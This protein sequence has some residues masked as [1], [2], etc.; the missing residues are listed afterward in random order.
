MNPRHAGTQ[1]GFT[2]L[3]LS[4]VLV[5]VALVTGMAVSG[6][7]GILSSARQFATNRRMA[8]IEQALVK[9]RTGFD[10]LPCPADLTIAQG[11]AN[12]GVEGA[13]PG[14]CIG[15]TPSANF[16]AAGATYTFATAAEGAVP[17][18]TL[19]LPNDFMYDGWGN[20]FRYAVDISM[21]A[22]GAFPAMSLTCAYG[23]V[24]VKD[25]NGTARSAAA[26]Y[27]L[28]SHGANGHG[29]YTQKGVTLNAGSVNA[30]EQTNCHCNS[31]GAATTYAPVYV[32]ADFSVDS[33]NALDNF[34]DLVTYKE[35]WQMRTDWD[36]AT[37]CPTAYVADGQN[38]R[39]QFF[40]TGGGYLGQFGTCGS[41]AGQFNSPSGIAID[42][43]GNVWVTDYDN[44]TVQEFSS[45]GAYIGGFGSYGIYAGNGTFLE[46]FGVAFDSSGNLWVTDKDNNRIQKFNPTGTW[47]MTI[48]GDKGDG[49][50]TCTQCSSTTACTCYQ[51][52][53]NGQFAFPQGP[54]VIDTSGNI[55]VNDAGNAR[56]QEF[57]SSGSWLQTINTGAGFQD[58]FGFDSSGNFWEQI[59]GY[60]VEKFNS[61]GTDTG[62]YL[63]K[64]DPSCCEGSAN[65][66]NYGNLATTV[67]ANGN[68][69]IT[70]PYNNRVQE[71]NSSGTWLRSIGG[72]PPY[73]CET[74]PSSSEPACASG[75]ANGQFNAPGAVA[76][77]SR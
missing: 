5:I 53:G 71:F 56:V 27:A 10:R 52:S 65:G 46:A 60:A 39:V 3:E 22:L 44:D 55:W 77:T 7:I 57:N 54:V 21:T 48:G 33:G 2:L 70:D 73:S 15:G 6:T 42:K 34:D 49:T 36:T 8:G 35:R 72:P 41:G 20:R 23:A 59:G 45:S 68:I 32:Q 18:V 12:Y 4:I 69:W 9:F 16:S 75:N 63:D 30:N 24:T 61:S 14:T 13:T 11:S 47:L 66:L 38:C 64:S 31:S 17:T 58:G 76:V 37:R 26:L 29:A 40:T 51:G 28:I 25:V 67:D 1:R 62:V 74:S 43:S 50:H 19:G